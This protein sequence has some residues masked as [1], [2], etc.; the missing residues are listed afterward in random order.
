MILRVLL[1][2][3]CDTLRQEALLLLGLLLLEL[4]LLLL[5]LLRLALLGTRLGLLKKTQ[6]GQSSMHRVN[7]SLH[8]STYKPFMGP[9][10]QHFMPQ[11]LRT[12]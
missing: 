5:L 11:M 10:R 7:A 2:Q 1:L 6:Q 3:C 9:K 8:L 12:S 4:R